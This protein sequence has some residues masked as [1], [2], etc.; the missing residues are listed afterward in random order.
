MYT[1][2]RDE[3]PDE[4]DVALLREEREREERRTRRDHASRAVVAWVM[5]AA[6]ALL[7]YDSGRAAITARQDG[8]PWRYPACVSL[9]CLL[10]LVW[11][12][13][14]AV[15]RRRRDRVSHRGPG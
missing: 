3:D 15:R 11:L 7:S 1:G 14:R 5:A 13:V 6:L 10:A 2:P 8:R 4:R 9:I 12:V